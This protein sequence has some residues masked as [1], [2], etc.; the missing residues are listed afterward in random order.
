MAG[1]NPVTRGFVSAATVKGW[2]KLANFFRYD[3][4]ELAKAQIGSGVYLSPTVSVRNGSRVSI[5]AGSHIGQWSCLWAGDSGGRIEIGEHA[6]LAPDVFITASDYDFDAGPGPVMDLPK[7][8][9]DV[10]IG[11][12]AW[13]GAKVVVVAGVTVGDGAI[14]AAGSVVTRDVPENAV[15]AGVPAQVIRMRGE[16]R[17]ADQ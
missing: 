14:V 13:L 6:L 4:R 10:R 8:E 15:A 3:S 12:N 7:R 9:G 1:K 11:S 16:R 17:D 5:G 2:A